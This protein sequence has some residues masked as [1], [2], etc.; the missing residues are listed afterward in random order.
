MFHDM[1]YND[2]GTLKSK[3]SIVKRENFSKVLESIASEGITVFYGGPVGE[4]IV[5]EVYF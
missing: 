3:G 5:N 2:D 1:F 4:E